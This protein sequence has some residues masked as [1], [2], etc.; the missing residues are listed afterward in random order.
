[1][2]QQLFLFGADPSEAESR[3]RPFEARP[4]ALAF[5]IV[6]PP[7]AIE[8]IVALQNRL[9]R[10]Q[11]LRGALTRPDRLRLVLW[12][13]GRFQDPPREAAGQAAQAVASM[14]TP[15]FE[16]SL[17]CVAALESAQ[18]RRPVVLTTADEGLHL[19]RLGLRLNAAL[20]QAGLARPSAAPPTPHVT[21]AHASAE[22]R[23]QL[24]EPIRWRVE[25]LALVH[26]RLGRSADAVLGRWPLT[27]PC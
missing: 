23:A 14:A 11:G 8:R 15:A 7:A 12:E 1:M 2:P 18:A 10:Q 24:V 22:I 25:D 4:H 6:P 21:L 17:D 19:A 5:A 16:A 13:I 27:A 26:S 20:V 3:P 9:A